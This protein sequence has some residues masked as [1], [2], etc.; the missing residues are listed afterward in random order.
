MAAL[1]VSCENDPV[2][3]GGG[4]GNGEPTFTDIKFTTLSDAVYYGESKAEGTGFFTFTLS[5]DKGD[6][7][8]ID[9]VGA[10]ALNSSNPRFT[11]GRYNAGNIATP[12]I[13]MF[14]TAESATDEVGTI[15]WKDAEAYPV[16]EGT[17]EAKA[18]GSNYQLT[19]K[20]KSGDQEIEATY[21]GAL[22]FESKPT[23][24]PRVQDPNPRPVQNLMGSYVGKLNKDSKTAAFVILLAYKGDDLATGKNMEAL[25][26]QGFM[27]IAEDR[28]NAYLPEGTYTITS[29]TKKQDAF[30]LTAGSVSEKDGYGGTYEI[31]TDNAGG[32]NKGYVITE[33]TLEVTKT[34]DNYK[35]TATMKG[36]RADRKS[37]L[38]TEAESVVYEY[39]GPMKPMANLA[40]APSN[41]T[42]DIDLGT[43][44]NQALLQIVPL[45]DNAYTGWFYF[46]WDE[47]IGGTIKDKE[48]DINGQGHTV[49]VAIIGKPQATDL[50]TGEFPMSSFYGTQEETGSAWPAAYDIANF[51][52]TT[53]CIYAFVK[54][55]PNTLKLLDYMGAVADKGFVKTSTAGNIHTVEFEYYDRNGHKVSGKYEGEVEVV[56]SSSAQSASG[57]TNALFYV[58]S[59]RVTADMD[60]ISMFLMR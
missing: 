14:A 26:I 33:G 53:G 41:L 59:Y 57:A 48:L 21:E 13:G 39:E 11:T 8:R 55:E 2:P 10:L 1:T 27:P 9:C 20:V 50:P 35:L 38:G 29:D 51:G 4:G 24:A 37:V 6:K 16:N 52:P 17:I 34:G 40:D 54:Q 12:E 46:L 25:S 28:N 45:E 3:P 43:F 31:Y 56:K 49:C 32:I 44:S 5:N 18:A 42:E 47:G 30:V 19:I 58:P 7:M 15:Y 36:K 23:F 60:P 22:K